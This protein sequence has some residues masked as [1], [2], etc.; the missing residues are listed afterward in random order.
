MHTVIL[1]GHQQTNNFNFIQFEQDLVSS[2][3]IKCDIF[4]QAAEKSTTLWANN[5]MLHLLSHNR[6]YPK[7]TNIHLK[8]ARVFLWTKVLLHYH[9][10][11]PIFQQSVR[12]SS[13]TCRE[14]AWFWKCIQRHWECRTMFKYLKSCKLVIINICTGV[15]KF[16][17]RYKLKLWKDIWF[18]QCA[19]VCIY[20]CLF[21]LIYF[22]L[23]FCIQCTRSSE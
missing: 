19:E 17:Y 6:G 5:G 14:N 2:P 20:I 21:F 10:P 18:Y 9:S 8:T 12:S 7:I 15:R 23:C 1:N 3:E 22:C 16:E 13:N 4:F 11:V